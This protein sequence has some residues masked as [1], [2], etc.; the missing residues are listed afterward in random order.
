MAIVVRSRVECRLG[1]RQSED[2]PAVT[3]IDRRQPKYI[4]KERPIRF[5]ILAVD[6]D[7]RTGNHNGSS[8][9]PPS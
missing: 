6:H 4:A 7:M 1:G 9:A 8:L 3:G 2:Q 5:C